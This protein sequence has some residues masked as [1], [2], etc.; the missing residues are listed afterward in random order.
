MRR[1]RTPPRAREGYP[2]GT[3]DATLPA[4]SISTFAY[5]GR[6]RTPVTLAVD[7]GKGYYP[8]R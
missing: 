3:P 7:P 5:T 6:R 2:N 1:N 8:K 4:R